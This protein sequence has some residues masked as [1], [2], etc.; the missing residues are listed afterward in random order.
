MQEEQRLWGV[1]AH[2]PRDGRYRAVFSDGLAGKFHLPSQKPPITEDDV[3][4]S[5]RFKN[6]DW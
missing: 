4:F 3:P 2:G 5:E 1:D 6:L